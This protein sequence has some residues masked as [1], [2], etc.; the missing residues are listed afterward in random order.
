M[1][2]IP[3]VSVGIAYIAICLFLQACDTVAVSRTNAT[4]AG[5][6]SQLAAQ[7]MGLSKTSVF[8]APQPR[9]FNYPDLFPGTSNVLPRAYQN[10]PPQIPHNIESFLPV[11]KDHN[12]CLQCHNR[13]DQQ[14]KVAEHQPTPIPASHYTDLRNAPGK[15]T[16]AL[17][18]ARY[19]CTQCHVPQAQVKMLVNNSFN[20]ND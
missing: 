7:D 15:V 18:G 6:A 2:I 1:K 9:P 12:L 5:S 17:V 16:N 3:T 20:P 13:P 19:I 10:A 14:G 4:A 8:D 11:A